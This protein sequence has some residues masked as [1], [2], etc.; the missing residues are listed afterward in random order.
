MLSLIGYAV[1]LG[2]VWRFPYL[3]Q[4]NGG[5]KNLTVHVL[6]SFSFIEWFC[7]FC[8]I[9]YIIILTIN[10]ILM[11]YGPFKN[12]SWMGR[13][14]L[15]FNKYYISLI[16]RHHHWWERLQNLSRF[17]ALTAFEQGSLSCHTCYNTA[18]R[19]TPSNLK[20]HPLRSP[21]MKWNA[22]GNWGQDLF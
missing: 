22:R 18:F 20:D 6:I 3:T 5:G 12:H 8:V 7:L 10:W 11:F 21:L 14:T 16:Q 2:N 13:K 9:L 1:G 4:K 15:I 19:F 17:S